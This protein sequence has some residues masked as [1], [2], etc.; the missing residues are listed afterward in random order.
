MSTTITLTLKQAPALR[1]D[2]RGVTPAALAALSVGAVERLSVT[3]GT[4]MLQLAELCCRA[5][6]ISGSP[7]SSMAASA[8]TS[9]AA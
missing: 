3:H 7:C 8:T 9:A 5:P 6:T 1:V 4:E 2:L